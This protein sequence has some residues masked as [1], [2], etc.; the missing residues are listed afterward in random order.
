MITAKEA[1]KLAYNSK[2]VKDSLESIEKIITEK[3]E[4]GEFECTV[5]CHRPT[6]LEPKVYDTVVSRLTK[7]GYK[8]KATIT[9]NMT[10]GFFPVDVVNY[11]IEWYDYKG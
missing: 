10:L 4:N 8:A 11:H 3:A 2:E 9:Q 6:L 7:L 1:Y 5:S